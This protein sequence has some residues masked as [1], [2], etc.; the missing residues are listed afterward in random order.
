MRDARLA[1]FKVEALAMRLRDSATH[2]AFAVTALPYSVVE[3]R[4]F[5]AAAQCDLI[6][7]CVDRPW[8]RHALNLLAYS[9]LIPV[10]DGGIAV[11]ASGGRLRRADWRAHLV[12]PGRR[13]LHCLGQYAVENVALEREGYLEDPTY[14]E[15]L[16]KD[17]LLRRS[18]NVI[19]FSSFTASMEVMQMLVGVVA[20][21]GVPDVG[22]QTYHFVGGVLDRDPRGCEEGCPFDSE[23]RGRGDDAGVDPTGRHQA[24]DEARAKR[25][26]TRTLAIR[27]ADRLDRR[28][29]R[30]L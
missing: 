8:P 29:R 4:G 26:R 21:A 25:E 3:P 23:L 15:G 10:V 13:C 28:L 22:A 12:A 1:R 16:A 18:E 5:A 17:H 6:F 19:A 27:M 11:Q 2:S 14:I 9:H 30:L 7:S 20:P 24:A